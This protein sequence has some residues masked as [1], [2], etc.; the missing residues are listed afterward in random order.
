MSEPTYLAHLMPRT[1]DSAPFWQACN[2]SR[3]VLRHCEQCDTVFY[4]P[5]RLCPACGS[6]RLGWRDASGRATV[7][8]FS[9]VQVPFAGPEWSTQVPYTVVLVDLEE[10]PRMVSRLIGESRADV[11][12]GDAL[13]V[14]FVEVDQQKLPFFQRIV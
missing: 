9:E 4:Y 11:K 6:T 5:R 10:G 13:E 8:S 2:E 3:L 1:E 7:F 12:I 14:C